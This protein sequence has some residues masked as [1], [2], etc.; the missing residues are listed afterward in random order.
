MRKT[1]TPVG[2]D[3]RLGSADEPSGPAA[4]VAVQSVLQLFR[5][6]TVN[7]HRR[8]LSLNMLLAAMQESNLRG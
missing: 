3:T 5:T 1:W 8:V 4:G 2:A 6:A 7:A